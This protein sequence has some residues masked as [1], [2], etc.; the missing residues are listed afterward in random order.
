MSADGI[1]FDM[2]DLAAAMERLTADAIDALPFGVI[3]I[4]RFGSVL[5]YSRTE[6]KRSGYAG[7]DPVGQ[8]FFSIGCFGGAGFRSRIE[9]ARQHGKVDLEIGW[10][11][12]FADP[13][14]AL[15]I[16]VQSGRGGKLW[17]FVQRDPDEDVSRD[18]GGRRSEPPCRPPRRDG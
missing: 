3:A 5:L 13:G 2:A 17:L 10:F 14:R 8:D 6:L 12:D 4:D 15:R 1:D 18:P 7:A 16:R 11:G 9:E